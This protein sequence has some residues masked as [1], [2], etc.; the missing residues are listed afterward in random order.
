MERRA[1]MVTTNRYNNEENPYNR[2]VAINNA[3]VT[4]LQGAPEAKGNDRVRRLGL[5]IEDRQ[6]HRST[7]NRKTTIQAIVST[8]LSIEKQILA[9]SQD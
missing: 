7:T 5:S 3:F 6:K 4:N 2:G 1:H 8:D 9:S